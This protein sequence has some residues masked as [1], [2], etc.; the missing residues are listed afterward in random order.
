[1]GVECLLEGECILCASSEVEVCLSRGVHPCTIRL[2]HPHQSGKHK[3]DVI[4]NF[5]TEENI[6]LHQPGIEPGSVPWQ[7]VSELK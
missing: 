7:D 3:N 1:M 2:C 5:K 6:N 4:K